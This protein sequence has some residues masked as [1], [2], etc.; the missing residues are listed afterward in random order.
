MIAWSA[1]ALLQVLADDYNEAGPSPSSTEP[2]PADNKDSLSPREAHMDFNLG[3]CEASAAAR[4]EH[5]EHDK[6]LLSN[7]VPEVRGLHRIPFVRR[8]GPEQGLGW[9]PQGNTPMDFLPSL[10]GR[11]IGATVT[12]P[13]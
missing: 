4:L 12:I 11:P 5:E 7:G 6:G 1:G 2:K 9:S 10:K 8:V 13:R 3:S